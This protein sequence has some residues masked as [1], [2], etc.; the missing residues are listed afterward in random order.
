MERKP[1]FCII[2]SGYSHVFARPLDIVLWRQTDQGFIVSNNIYMIK[3][4]NR[5]KCIIIF[6]DDTRQLMC[7]TYSTLHASLAS[8]ASLAVR[9]EL[10]PTATSPGLIHSLAFS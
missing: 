8:L 10:A 9:D 5:R 6:G 2:R 1:T 3:V 4:V 7:N